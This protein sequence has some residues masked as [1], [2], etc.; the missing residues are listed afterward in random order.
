MKTPP[1][2]TSP[3]DSSRM[4]RSV[5]LRQNST[6]LIANYTLVTAASRMV[7]SRP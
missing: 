2:T 1:M 3:R 4:K 6:R 7:V 5:D